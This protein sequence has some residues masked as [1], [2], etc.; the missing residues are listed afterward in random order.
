MVLLLQ[1]NVYTMVHGTNDSLAN[2][3]ENNKCAEIPLYSFSPFFT[4]DWN[5]E[6]RS[7]VGIELNKWNSHHP[8]KNGCNPIFGY[9][10]KTS[11]GESGFYLSP[12]GLFSVTDII[13]IIGISIGPELGVG[14]S[15]FNYGI[16][17]RGW[18]S[19]VGVQ[20]SEM[21]NDEAKC[22]FYIFIPFHQIMLQ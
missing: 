18:I 17:A 10:I 8:N 2:K 6:K 19:F 20:F 1:M 21:K 9:G 15:G 5:K 11:V 12:Y 7:E 3:Y 16:S 4:R 22:A 14:R 13:E